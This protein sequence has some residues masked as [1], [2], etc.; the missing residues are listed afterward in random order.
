MNRLLNAAAAACVF[1]FSFFAACVPA[2]RYQEVAA[3]RDSLRQEHAASL[4]VADSLRV[5]NRELA[6]DKARLEKQVQQLVS[7]SLARGEAFARTADELANL[8]Y[9]Y[10]QLE[11][12]QKSIVAG[13]QREISKML[14]E[15]Q[16]MQSQLQ[17]RED[18][19]KN[20]ESQL[21]QRKQAL[22]RV[23]KQQAAD[24][25]ALDSLRSSLDEMTA[26]LNEK[27]KTLEA[28]Q[29]ALARKD[30]AS[31][32]LKDRIARALFGFQGQGL[33]VHEKNGRVHISIEDKLL[34]KS[35]SYAIG[36]QGEAAIRQLVPILEQYA[37]LN[38]VVEGHTDDVPMK[39]SGPIADN[40]DLSAKRAT[41]IVKLMLQGSTLSPASIS[42]SGRAEFH[43]I[44]DEKTPEA[45]QKNRRTEII[46]TPNLSEIM[47]LLN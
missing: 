6:G 19:V 25:R 40:W 39:G 10:G 42:A 23:E 32:A 45:R 18:A 29:Q 37:D 3:Q 15:M 20:L 46:L 35:G 7:D 31:A 41:T 21:F 12:N 2:K 9:S 47:G 5:G 17:Q 14:S 8:K 24:R 4:R 38:I 13:N 27:H 44:L 11:A 26:A 34:F 1:S 30:S 16:R 36:P 33:T 22:D 43:P 28:L